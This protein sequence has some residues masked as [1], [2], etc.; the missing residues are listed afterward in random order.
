MASEKSKTTDNVSVSSTADGDAADNIIK[1]PK[2]YVCMYVCM[3]VCA[4]NHICMYVCM[5]VLYVCR[6]QQIQ[7]RAKAKTA[8]RMI[9]KRRGE[10]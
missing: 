6:Q 2:V 8:I 10:L 1:Q 7:L 5:Y 9:R 4:C 3:Y